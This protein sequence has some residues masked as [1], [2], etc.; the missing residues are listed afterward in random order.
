MTKKNHLITE[1]SP[2]LLQHAYNPVDWYPWGEASLQR[3]R[4]EDKMIL[5]SIG[6]SAC[7]WCHVMEHESFEDDEVAEIMNK[8]FVCIKVD[9]E[10]RPD[11]DQVYMSAVQLMTG[12]GGWPLNCFTLPDGRPVYGGTYFPKQQWKNILLNLAEGFKNDRAKFTDYAEQLTE[13]IQKSELIPPSTETPA[14]TLELLETSFKN[15]EKHFDNHEGGPDRAPKFPLPN[16]YLFLLKYESVYKNESLKNHIALT[17]KKMAYGGIY[18]QIGGGFSRYSVDGIW[19]VPHFEK[20]LYDNSQLISLYSESYKRYKNTLYRDVVF[21]TLEFVKR[22]LTGSEGNFYSALDADSEG[23]EGKYYTWTKAELQELLGSDFDFFADVF[24]VNQ[25]GFWE[26]DVHILLRDADDEVLSK[27]FKMDVPSFKSKVRELSEKVLVIREKRIHPGLDDKTLLSWNALMVTG[28]L[29]AFDAFQ[30]KE[31]LEIAKTNIDFVLEKMVNADGGLYHSYKN[32]KASFNGFLEDYAFFIQA[33]IRMYQVT[34]EISY[35]NK[36][37]ELTEYT[38]QN[39]SD[40]NHA[41]LYFASGKDTPLITRSKEIQ[42]NVIPAS[43]SQMAINLFFL[44]HYFENAEWLNKSEVMVMSMKASLSAYGS[45][46]SN[47]L[48]LWLYQSQPLRELVIC[49]ADALQKRQEIFTEDL[50]VGIIPGGTIDSE[51]ISMTHGRLKK[52][53]TLIY[54]CVNKQ[55]HLPVADVSEAFSLLNN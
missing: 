38:L 22:E 4:D 54:V 46:F 5:V 15:W 44:G 28:Y 9:R 21:Q 3:A 16:N 24:N 11:I 31:W 32:D 37:K 19:K 23:V 8:F 6:Y 41:L 34:F 43:N 27:K 42:D 2:Y 12:R 1:S 45:G 40:P 17:L 20:M 30:E 13:G 25:K 36:A 52:D 14:F 29:D 55:C 26:H 18:D 50:P 51:N 39:F 33:L 49:G 10:E 53:Q 7:H 48:L 47:W 35:L